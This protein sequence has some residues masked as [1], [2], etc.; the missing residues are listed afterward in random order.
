LSWI[1][2]EDDRMMK[3]LAVAERE[4]EGEGANGSGKELPVVMCEVPK[5][6]MELSNGS[7]PGAKED[8][9]DA[10]EDKAGGSEE[11]TSR[12]V[13]LGVSNERLELPKGSGP[14]SNENENPDETEENGSN[15][16]GA[17]WGPGSQAW[18]ELEAIL[19]A[20]CDSQ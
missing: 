3:Y 19:D 18:D 13:T 1:L 5:R 10:R 8:V 11:E 14:E 17:V 16:P 9:E 12:I 4:G 7:V 2:D 20:S 15:C 6:R